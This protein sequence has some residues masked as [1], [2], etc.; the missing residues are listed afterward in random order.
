MSIPQTPIGSGFDSTSTTA[1][2][3][4]GIDLSENS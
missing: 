3:S 1:D 4:K 2:V